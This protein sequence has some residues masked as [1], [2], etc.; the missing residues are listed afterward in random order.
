MVGVGMLATVTNPFWYAWWVTV[1]AGYLAQAREL[2]LASVAAF[3]LGHIGADFGWNTALSAVFG[4]GRRWMS[5][6]V[7]RC[8]L[9]L[10]GLFLAYLGAT[11][12]LQGVH[13]LR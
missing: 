8:I 12:L 9:G 2:G 10:C 11:F 13:L 1:A 5:A 6:G 3:Y 7:Y 4:S